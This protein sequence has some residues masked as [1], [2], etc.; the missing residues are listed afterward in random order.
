MAGRGV[1]PQAARSPR[2]TLAPMAI[3]TERLTELADLPEVA[4]D[5]SDI[6]E[7]TEAFFRVAKLR[8]FKTVRRTLET[9]PGQDEPWPEDQ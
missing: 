3:S 7:A 1:L 2:L 8:Q 6:A 5:K 9:S 4:I